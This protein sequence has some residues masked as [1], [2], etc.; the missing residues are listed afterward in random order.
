MDAVEPARTA[1][2]PR[3]A[4]VPAL[5]AEQA[6]RAPDA[7]A[8]GLGRART[9]TYAELDAASDAR[10]ARG[11]GRCGWG[12]RRGWGSRWSAAPALIAAVLGVLKA[13]AA[14][15]PLDAEYP[16]ARL[17][18]M[19]R[20]CR[21]RRADRGGRGPG[22]ALA[23]LR[24]PG[25][26]RWPGRPDGPARMPVGPCRRGSPRRSRW[27]A[28]STPPAPPARPRG[29]AIT[30]P[31]HRA[32]GARAALRAAARRARGRR[33]PPPASTRTRGRCGAR[34]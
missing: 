24:R 7:A 31:R 2:Y 8:R 6:A 13:G 11:C 30:A 22:A 21:R 15:V 9:L 16:A 26:L 23:A 18:F 12:R 5:F 29:S 3:D 33:A 34:C 14:Y 25:V 4:T 10:R 20:D 32:A 17:A 19:L 1:D 28:S 27:R